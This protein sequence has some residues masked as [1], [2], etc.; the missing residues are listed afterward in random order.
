MIKI[1]TINIHGIR[2]RWLDR[3]HM[4][5]AGLLDEEPDL[6]ALQEVNVA[7]GQGSWITGQLNARLGRKT[8]T[9]LQQRRKGFISGFL[10]GV[11]ILSKWP[12]ILKEGLDLGYDGR[13][14][15]LANIELP[16]GGTVDFVS[17]RLTS[18][19]TVPE[20]RYEQ[21][22]R[23]TGWLGVPGRSECQIVVGDFNDLPDSIAMKR[24]S[25]GMRS[26]FE[27]AHGREPLATFPTVLAHRDN[28]WTGCLDY[29]FVT[30]DV[31]VHEAKFFGQTHHP[32]DD[33]LYMSDH[34]GL[35]VQLNMLE[36]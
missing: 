1:L 36:K 23:L 9:L 21:V 16:G 8:Y 24:M 13:V 11:A 20:V 5:I 28:D 18:G 25:Q 3:R 15:L 19:Q 2:D 30:Q 10:D 17:V 7:A 6:I 29:V 31:V 4:L 32:D 35:V 33:Q 26:A 14:A 34:I 27:L 22:M 12:V